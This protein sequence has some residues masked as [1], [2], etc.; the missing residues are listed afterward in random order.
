MIKVRFA[1][2]PTG[3]LHIGGLRTALYNYLFARHNNGIFLLRIEDTDRSRFVEGAAEGLVDILKWAGLD[4]DEGPLFQSDRLDIYKE[5]VDFLLK[6]GFAYR[7]F[8]SADRLDGMRKAQI[9]KK[10]P[11]KYDGLCKSL[12]PEESDK[13][14][15]EKPFTVRMK[16]PQ[17]EIIF[18]DA[19]RGTVKFHGSLIDDQVILKSDGYPTYHLANVVDD[20]MMG[21]THVIRGEEWLSSTPKHII[22]YRYFGWNPPVFAHLPLLLNPDK[23]KLSKRQGDVAVESYKEKGY[24]PEAVLNYVLL[25]GWATEDSQQIFSKEEMIAKFSI[26]RC[27]K[28]GAIFDIQ[29]LIWMNGEYIRKLPIEELTRR[30]IP[31]IEKAG[32]E[33]SDIGYLQKCVFLEQEKIKLLSDV[34]H[35]IDFFLKDDIIYDKN[36]LDKVVKKPGVFEILNDI[37]VVYSELKEFTEQSTETV[38][39]EYAIKKSLKTAQIFHPVRVAVS[40]RTEGPSLFHMLELLGRDR[41]LKRVNYLIGEING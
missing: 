37:A 38:T 27:G 35:L 26:E 7:C 16:M 33:A 19:I 3:F 30:A 36:A 18:D 28:S 11:P 39:R 20:R 5:R 17:E 12:S 25:L 22:L 34:P 24:L 29:K 23:S 32:F 8:C 2:S 6:N 21:I 41:V 31:F 1:P 14:A 4:F 9:A 10:Q 13:L 40:G 15:K